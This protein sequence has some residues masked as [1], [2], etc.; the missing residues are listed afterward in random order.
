MA[1]I[2][3]MNSSASLPRD[4]AEQLEKLR[5]NIGDGFTDK[6]VDKKKR[7][8][9]GKDDFMKLMSAQLKYQDPVSPMKNQEMAA[10]LAQFSSL[11]QMFN[12][13][14]NLEKM[15]AGQ[16]PQENVMAASLIGKKIM[17][18]ASRIHYEKGKD[19]EFSFDMA[20][21]AAIGTV[22]IVNAKGEVVREMALTS[23]RAG[24]QNIKWDGRGEKGQAMESG[25]YSFRVTATDANNKPVQADLSTAGIVT[26][27]SFE[28]GRPL[29]LVGDKKVSME[30]V[31]RIEE[32]SAKE[33]A[34]NQMASQAFN[35]Q[36]A[37]MTAPES[38][39]TAAEKNVGQKNDSQ[40]NLSTAQPQS[41]ISNKEA[42]LI[43][44]QMQSSSGPVESEA[45]N[46]PENLAMNAKAGTRGDSLW[47]PNN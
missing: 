42:E 44:R 40:K 13:N 29:L 37:K 22:S 7:N 28:K 33:L 26:G 17:T 43:A 18:D 25:E 34:Q 2:R 27:I 30:S 32:V 14:Q 41:T 35:G 20:G 15:A 12:V 45:S 16:R 1:D 31:S 23:G 11:E 4:G 9:M 38:A 39:T 10:Q 8:E 3:S 21:A 6:P 24:T 5:K 19:A 46:E 47:N 36:D